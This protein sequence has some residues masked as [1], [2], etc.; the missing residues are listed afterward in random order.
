MGIHSE[1]LSQ[2]KA[3]TRIG[4]VGKE[5]EEKI[6]LMMSSAHTERHLQGTWVGSRCGCAS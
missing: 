4:A 3:G 1:M 2:E 5:E 6:L